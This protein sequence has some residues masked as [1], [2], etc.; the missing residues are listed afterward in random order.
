[1]SGD[2]TFKCPNCGAPLDVPDGADVR[3]VECAYCGNSVIVPRE[4]RPEQ[5]QLYQAVVIQ[6]FPEISVGDAATIALP[7]PD[8]K[9]GRRI[10]CG[11]WA[12][13]L[14]IIASVALSVIVPLLAVWPNFQPVIGPQGLA[15]EAMTFGSSGTGP[16]RFEQP[17]DVAVDGEGYIYVVDYGNA[18]VQ[19]FD[20]DG[21][22]VSGWTVEGEHPEAVAADRSGN[23][24]V[25]VDQ[26]IAKYEGKSGSPLGT[27]ETETIFGYN[28]LALFP[29]GDLL[30]YTSDDA[31]V[32]LDPNGR[33]VGRYPD[34]LGKVSGESRPAPWLV[35]L[36]VDGLGNMVVLNMG[37]GAGLF[38]YG[39]DGSY[40]NRIALGD[41]Q[42]GSPNPQA[43]AID[44]KS[45]IY[46]S[47]WKRIQVFDR[48]GRSLGLINLS[49]Y[50][51]PTG[52]AFNDQSELFVVA[53]FVDSVT[54]FVLND[55]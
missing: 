23:V 52:M 28:D 19:R 47:D 6:G 9:L 41:G 31:L 29:N 38:V 48:E 22:Y 51:A 16:G 17:I 12:I 54:K 21:K 37:S 40:R 1:M 39:P 3:E 42:A 46:V 14:T 13:I 15:R 2:S 45:R 35:R 18:R 20:K 8:K 4:L 53:R 43:V 49:Y 27:F 30:A 34:A 32:R 25:V 5:P 11:V 33:E 44:A 50:Y 36:A 10:A 26:K 55:P 7:R 24:Y